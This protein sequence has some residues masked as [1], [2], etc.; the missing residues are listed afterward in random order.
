MEQEER[1]YLEAVEAESELNTTV[2]KL[3]GELVV[4]KH[5]AQTL[6]AGSDRMSRMRFAASV[7]HGIP[8]KML[9]AE[10]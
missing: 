10:I 7:Q 9:E 4:A 6:G 8:K 1:E 2:N 3:R 5:E